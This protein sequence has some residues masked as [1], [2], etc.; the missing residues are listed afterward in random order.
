M[1]DTTEKLMEKQRLIR[2]SWSAVPPCLLDVDGAAAFLGVTPWAVRML[3][4][5]G[6]LSPTRIGEGKTAKQLLRRKDLEA[7]VETEND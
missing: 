4:K 1:R 3:I 6:K 2:A 5:R 7:F